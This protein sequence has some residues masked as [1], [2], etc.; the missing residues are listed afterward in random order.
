M[1]LGLDKY[2]TLRLE[3]GRIGVTQEGEQLT[4][5]IRHL[6]E[7]ETYKY[8]EIRANCEK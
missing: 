6:G 7:D 1:E 4:A 2:A 8:L 5:N 3:I